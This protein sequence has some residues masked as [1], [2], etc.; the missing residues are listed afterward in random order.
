M[1]SKT[2]EVIATND[3]PMQKFFHKVVAVPKSEPLRPPGLENPPTVIS[4]DPDAIYHLKQK[5]LRLIIE[6]TMLTEGKMDRLFE[7][8]KYANPWIGAE[9]LEANVFKFIKN[10]ILG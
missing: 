10:E 9:E 1:F 4:S 5:L 7:K 8:T 2:E 3:A 6:K